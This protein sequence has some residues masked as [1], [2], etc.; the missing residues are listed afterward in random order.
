MPHNFSEVYVYAETPEATFRQIYHDITVNP[1]E[2]L[3]D[4]SHIHVSLRKN[5]P[6]VFSITN[7]IP[8]KGAFRVGTG[9]SQR[10][11]F[12]TTDPRRWGASRVE[13]SV[14]PKALV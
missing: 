7:E 9:S 3:I 10:R 11:A 12:L 5:I 13:G 14:L 1:G 2:H 8:R 6:N 4:K